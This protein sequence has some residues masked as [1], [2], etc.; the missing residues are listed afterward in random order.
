M[1]TWTIAQVEEMAGIVAQYWPSLFRDR[2]DVAKLWTGALRAYPHDEVMETLRG[3]YIVQETTR[4]PT[5][6]FIRGELRTKKS[7]REQAA[8]LNEKEMSLSDYWEDYQHGRGKRHSQE[9]ETLLKK[10]AKGGG[11]TEIVA[12]IREPGE[13]G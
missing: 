5:L 7:K 6:A 13:E 4:P 10:A 8:K 12:S 1:M 9:G 2:E 11:V 3:V